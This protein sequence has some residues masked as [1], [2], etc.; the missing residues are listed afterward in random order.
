MY[1][2]D[3]HS[4]GS[5]ENVPAGCFFSKIDLRDREKTAQYISEVKPDVVYAL[6]ANA[7]EGASFF[8]PLDV[9]ERN[10][11]VYINVLEPAIKHGIEKIIFFSSMAAYGKQ[12]PPF[13]ETLERKPC[14][15]YGLSKAWCEQTTEMLSEAHGFKYV[16]IRPHNVAGRR[17]RL[18]DIFRNVIAIF[19]NRILR[20]EPI[21]I[22]GDGE[23]KRAFSYIDFSLPCYLRCMDDDIHSEIFN[24]GGMTEI[25][26]NEVAKMVIDCFQGYKIPDIIHIPD[27]HGEVKYAWS[28]YQKSVDRLGYKETF[29]IEE[30]IKRMSEWAK[31]KG[32]QKWTEEKLS[33]INDKVPATWTM[34]RN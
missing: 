25:T 12:E 10:V 22:Y 18:N 4:G 11:N 2:V 27:R 34:E 1:G 14:D 31:M 5:P 24:I 17:Q 9:T 26:V 7:R 6:A 3:D 15:V 30:G 33:I 19:M 32:P 13:D 21:Y 23:Q 8:Q 28:T 16:I 20:G 29:S